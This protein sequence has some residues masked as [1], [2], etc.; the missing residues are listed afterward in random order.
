[1]GG[2]SSYNPA[3]SVFAGMTTDAKTALLAKAQAAYGDLLTGG[4]PVSVAYGQG[5]G[6]RTVTYTP[7]SAGGLASLIAQLQRELGIT[8]RARRPVRFAF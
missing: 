3:N 6:M 7:A 2:C 4:K 5:D 1:M 8:R